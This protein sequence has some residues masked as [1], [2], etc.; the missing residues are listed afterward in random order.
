MKH[1][2]CALLEMHGSLRSGVIG[3]KEGLGQ[4]VALL[5]LS[6]S[7]M[8]T[9]LKESSPFGNTLKKPNLQLSTL[10]RSLGCSKQSLRFAIGNQPCY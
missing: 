5:Y 9:G 7:E 8:Q 3:Q 4:V 10:T 6:P 2:S 1:I